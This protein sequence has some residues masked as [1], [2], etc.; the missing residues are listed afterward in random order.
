MENL[1]KKEAT[2][3]GNQYVDYFPPLR[4]DTILSDIFSNMTS[5]QTSHKDDG[6]SKAMRLIGNDCYQMGD[7]VSAMIAYNKSLRYAEIGSTNVAMGYTNRSAC[8]FSMQMYAEALIDVQLAEKAN[9]PARLV[10]MLQQRKQESQKLLNTVVKPPIPIR[11]LSYK[12]NEHFPCLAN[13]IELK[14]DE[15]F[16]RHLVAKCDIPV[17]KIVLLEENYVQNEND[18]DLECKF[19]FDV[20]KNSI[21]C[22]DCADV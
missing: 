3:A 14:H 9:L 2:P 19:C 7:W 4:I 16:G 22:N 18:E 11:K 15:E 10:P 1:W 21:A 12:A 5:S 6:Y 8:F 17:G 20:I 13:V